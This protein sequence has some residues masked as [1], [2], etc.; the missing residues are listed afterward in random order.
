MVAC[1]IQLAVFS[2]NDSPGTAIFGA[3]RH[4]GELVVVATPLFWQ[5]PIKV[6]EHNAVAGV[7]KGAIGG[8]EVKGVASLGRQFGRRYLACR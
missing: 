6:R 7:R 2:G 8:N 1:V 3:R 5:Q 4:H